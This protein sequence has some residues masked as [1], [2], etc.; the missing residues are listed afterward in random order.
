MHS[1]DGTVASGTP[2][3]FGSAQPFGRRAGKSK[4]GKTNADLAADKT[5][6]AKIQPKGTR[7]QSKDR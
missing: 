5:A 7:F 6:L 3:E 4:P 1:Q 2:F